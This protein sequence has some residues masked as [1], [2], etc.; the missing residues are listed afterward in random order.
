MLKLE[1]TVASSNSFR[2]WNKYVLMIQAN[3]YKQLYCYSSA[4]LIPDFEIVKV[5]NSS[6]SLQQSAYSMRWIY[7]KCFFFTVVHLELSANNGW[8]VY[9]LVAWSYTWPELLCRYASWL[10]AKS[11][12]GR[13]RIAWVLYSDFLN[14]RTYWMHSTCTNCIVLR[15]S[16]LYCPSYE[17][18]IS[19]AFDA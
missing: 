14:K 9:S 4:Y 10:S 13:K 6:K 16:L 7:I 18:S 3:A 19:S 17:I 12:L 1:N 8:L 5:W 11:F 2:F 15:S